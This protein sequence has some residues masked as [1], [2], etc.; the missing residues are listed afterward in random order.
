MRP[1][2]YDWDAQ[3]FGKVSDNEIARRLGCSSSLV[4]YHRKKRGI[5]PFTQT[6]RNKG[7]DWNSQ[8]LGILTDGELARRL[9]CHVSSVLQARKARGIP[10]AGST[11]ARLAAAREQARALFAEEAQK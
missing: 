9:G 6:N 5:A 10:A 1:R 4:I 7:I 2:K 11:A 8:L 3:P